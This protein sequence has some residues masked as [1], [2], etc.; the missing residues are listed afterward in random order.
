M[1]TWAAAALKKFATSDPPTIIL[2]PL[3]RQWMIWS[4]NRTKGLEFVD[5]VN[6]A[7]PYIDTKRNEIRR[8][9]ATPEDISLNK[10]E[11]NAETLAGP[12]ETLDTTIVAYLLLIQT[13]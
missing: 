10:R 7:S 9:D 11:A 3:G 2:D 8:L 6:A 13:L 4:I 12:F 1:M 5:G